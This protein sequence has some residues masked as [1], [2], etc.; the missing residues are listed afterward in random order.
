MTPATILKVD[1]DQV[2]EA[3]LVNGF[4]EGAGIVG[5]LGRVFIKA[6]DG[7]RQ[8]AR[9]RGL[10]RATRTREQI[11]VTDA[12][13]GNRVAQGL[14]DMLLADNFGPALRAVFAIEAWD[15]LVGSQIVL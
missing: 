7:L 4:E 15:I 5:A 12:V 8:Q 6:V 11:R 2:E 1:F 9:Q 13:R 14:H 3:I 10:A